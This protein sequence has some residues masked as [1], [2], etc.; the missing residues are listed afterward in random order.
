MRLVFFVN[1]VSTEIDEYTTTRLAI[2]ATRLGHDV[3][4][5]GAGDVVY[6]PRG[7]IS[8]K[9]HRAAHEEGDDLTSFLERVKKKE[10]AEDLALEDVDAVVLRNDSIEDMHDRPWAS[11]SGMFFGRMLAQKGVTVVNDPDGLMRAG[12]KLYL[13]EFPAAVRPRCL[14]ARDVDAIKDFVAE[15]G[16]TILKPLYGAKGRNVFLVT[17]AEDPNLSQ[18]IEAVLEDGYVIAQERIEGAEDG[19]VR[20]FLV[21]GELLQIDSTIAAFK[22]VPPTDDVRAN[23]STGGKPEPLEVGERELRIVELMKDQ[24]KKDGMFFVGIDIIGEKVVEVNAESPGGMQAVEHF[25]GLDFAVPVIEA[26]AQK[27]TRTQ[28]EPKA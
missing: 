17:D 26:L 1:E 25:T 19:D 5:V 20:L 2:A 24:L 6:E 21:D 13:E 18:M 7:T 28:G 12:S 3:W 23:I 9:A 14:V 15:T 8:A 27:A 16:P 11:M 4:Y 22:R 10:S